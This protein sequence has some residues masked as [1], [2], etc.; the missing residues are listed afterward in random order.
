M[1]AWC[2]WMS[3]KGVR[4]PG[5]WVTG[6]ESPCVLGTEPRTCKNTQ[7]SLWSWFVLSF[8]SETFLSVMYRKSTLFI[9]VSIICSVGCPSSP[10]THLPR[11]RR[12]NNL[13]LCFSIDKWYLLFFFFFLNLTWLDITVL[14]NPGCPQ[15]HYLAKDSPEFSLPAL[16][17]QLELQAC[18]PT[19]TSLPV[20]TLL[21]TAVWASVGHVCGWGGTAWS[22]S[23]PSVDS[24]QTATF[25]PVSNAQGAV[26][27]PLPARVIFFLCR[28][29]SVWVWTGRSAHCGSDLHG[30][31]VNAGHH[32]TFVDNSHVLLGEMS[33]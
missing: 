22:S 23:P 28:L 6:C 11:T 5:A 21:W 20:K 12:D 29:P 16:A 17:S 15:I 10:G 14:Y 26:S 7:C 3:N 18:V 9:K 25:S 30:P 8:F 19:A 2:P 32:F 31:S 24:W 33:T 1:S 13:M 4:A 27:V